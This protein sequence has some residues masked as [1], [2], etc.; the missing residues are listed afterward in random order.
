M[1][2]NRLARRRTV[3]RRGSI[4]AYAGEPLLQALGWLWLGVYS[5]ICGGTCS[6]PSSLRRYWVLSPRV[7]RNRRL[8]APGHSV[9]WSSPACAGEPYC[10]GVASSQGRVY[11]RGCG[12]TYATF[13]EQR[14]YPGLS[15]RVRGNRGCATSSSRCIGSIPACAGEPVIRSTSEPP[16]WVYPRVCGGTDAPPLQQQAGPGLSPRVRGNRMGVGRTQ[17]WRRSI[18]ACAGEPL[19]SPA[20]P[21]RI[22]VYPRVCGGTAAAS[23]SARNWG[24]YPRVCGGTADDPDRV[25][26]YQGLSRVCGG[27]CL[28]GRNCPGVGGLSPRVR[29]NQVEGGSDDADTVAGLSPR[30]RG[31]LHRVAVEL[32]AE[33]SI[34]ACAGEPPCAQRPCG[35]HTVYPRVCGGTGEPGETPGCDDGLSPRVRGNRWRTGFLTGRSRSIP[36]CAGEPPQ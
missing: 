27:T 14:W 9:G 11:P 16:R 25:Y 8:R 21:S 22:R 30:V 20:T 10:R 35:P 26:A 34:P 32:I 7:R 5:R 12:G 18:P 6:Y 31:N 17:T 19:C 28:S 24:V 3:G 2:G 29:G 23:T 33:G 1:R 13:V 36:A 15:P 4:P